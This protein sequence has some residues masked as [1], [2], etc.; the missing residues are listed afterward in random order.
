MLTSALSPR[1]NMVVRK[2][3][4]VDPGRGAMVIDYEMVNR[5]WSPASWAPWEITRVAPG[6]LTFYATG[7]QPLRWRQ[8]QFALQETG[9]VSW[10]AQDPHAPGG[11]KL[12]SDTQAGF[13]AH[14]DGQLLLTKCFAR[15]ESWQ[16]APGEGQIEIYNGGD[17][18]EVENQGAF[19]EIAPGKSLRWRV[20]WFLRRL[21]PDTKAVAGDQNLANFAQR[22]CDN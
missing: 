16:A 21:P 2:H 19:E 13:I 6:G 20:L 8:P 5:H 18:V 9:G 4:S 1:V 7:S 15:I 17:Y 10:V 12:T 3:F 11:G 22:L 14:T